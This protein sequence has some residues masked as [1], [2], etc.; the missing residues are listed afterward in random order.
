M[1]YEY[2]FLHIQLPLDRLAGQLTE[3]S[4]E[5]FAGLFPQLLDAYLLAIR[6][7]LPTHKGG[8]WEV[9]SHDFLRLSQFL[10]L[11]LL[12]RRPQ[13]NMSQSA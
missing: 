8:G 4:R 10:V 13:P 9:I 11:T 1:D 2:S 7:H 5:E 3:P 6:Q 12:L